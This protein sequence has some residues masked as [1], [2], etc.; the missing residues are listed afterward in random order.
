MSNLN[1]P[2]PEDALREGNNDEIEDQEHIIE[3]KAV[4]CATCHVSWADQSSEPII[5]PKLPSKYEDP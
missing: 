2:Q 3:D 4:T 1:R 5:Q